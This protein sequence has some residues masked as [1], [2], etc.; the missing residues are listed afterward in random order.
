MPPHLTHKDIEKC[1]AYMCTALLRLA[2]KDE[3]NL[4]R[5]WDYICDQYRNFYRDEIAFRITPDR[6]C[7][8][9][10]RNLLQ[11]RT[12]LRNT[13][14]VFLLAFQEL[15]G[16]DK[17]LCKMLYEVQMCYVGIHAYSLLLYCSARL[18][19]PISEFATLLE[20]PNTSKSLETVLYILTHYEFPSEES[21]EMA[22]KAKTWRSSRNGVPQ[23]WRRRIWR[24]NKNKTNFW[25][26]NS[27]KKVV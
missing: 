13:V 15:E 6:E 16:K 19:A 23:D 10:I 8:A 5:A 22:E 3:D 14:G 12:L 1:C 21:K 27:T 7:I 11:T 24:C 25:A 4:I 2:V 18:N 9:G 17:N 26:Y 20:H